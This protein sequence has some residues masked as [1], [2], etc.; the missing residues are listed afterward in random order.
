MAFVWPKM[1]QAWLFDIHLCMK[2][3]NGFK[4]NYK[5]FCQKYLYFA[6]TFK[7]IT[8]TSVEMEMKTVFSV[9]V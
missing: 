9:V 6:E 2:L 1:I 5:V 4:I 8:V 7:I 3:V